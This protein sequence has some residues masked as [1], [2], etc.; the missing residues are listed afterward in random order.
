MT[1]IMYKQGDLL[2]VKVD[3]VPK[4]NLVRIF[5]DAI[6]RGETWPRALGPCS[7]PLSRPSSSGTPP[8]QDRRGFREDCEEDTW[9]DEKGEESVHLL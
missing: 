3:R 6:V 2:F 9:I 1:R 5:D 8:R 4:R 7:A